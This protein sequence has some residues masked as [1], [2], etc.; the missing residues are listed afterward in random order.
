MLSCKKTNVTE[1]RIT[2]HHLLTF[3]SELSPSPLPTHSS[4]LQPNLL[5]SSTITLV[6]AY[7]SKRRLN[8]RYKRISPNQG[9]L[10]KEILSTLPTLRHIPF[11][12]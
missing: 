7:N 3:P 1:Q 6:S 8:L 5:I 9:T 11:Q 12:T 10:Q 2:L 4:T